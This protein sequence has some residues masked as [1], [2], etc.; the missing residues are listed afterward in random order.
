MV[1]INRFKYQGVILSDPAR[2]LSVK[3]SAVLR[4]PHESNT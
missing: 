4:A 2:F 3:L 1:M